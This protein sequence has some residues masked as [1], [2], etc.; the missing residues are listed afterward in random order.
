MSDKA[1]HKHPEKKSKLEQFNLSFELNR[2][3]TEERR[4]T[5]RRTEI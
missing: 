3:V 1:T 5:K 2:T 4:A